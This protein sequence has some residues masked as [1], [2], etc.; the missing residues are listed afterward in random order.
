MYLTT[1]EERA[2]LLGKLG[3]DVVVTHPFSQQI[4][5]MTAEEFMQL[6]CDHL[7][8]QQ[9]WVGQDFALGRGREGNVSML[10]RLGEKMSFH[11][12]VIP[13][14]ELDGQVIS[15]SQIR[16]LVAKGDVEGAAR[17][18]GRPF[19]V[20]G[21][22][23]PG[24]GRGRT[25]GIPTANLAV[26]DGLVIP[27]VGVYA[28]QAQVDTWSGRTWGAVTNIGMRPTFESNSPVPRVETHLL[29]FREDIYGKHVQLD[30]LARLRDEQRFPSVEA[31]VAQIQ[32]DIQR[33]RHLLERVYDTR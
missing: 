27:G 8:V 6:V 10:E 16:A 5:R 31:L 15:S 33:A 21:W 17:L 4:A 25:I 3:V 1:P 22:V 32:A 7:G 29:D 30:F 11:V 9:L 26:W 20:V 14:V 24:D 28:C 12:N 19:R 23:E 2:E 18:L 13:P